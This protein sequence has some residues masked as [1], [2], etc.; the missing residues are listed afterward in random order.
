M[1]LNA[2]NVHNTIMHCLFNDEELTSGE[3]IS[4]IAVDG[5]TCFFVFNPERLEEKWEDISSMLDCLPETFKNG[6]SFLNACVTKDDEHWGEHKDMDA[7]FSLGLAINRVNLAFPRE[8]WETL[9]G[10]M[11]Y[12]IVKEAE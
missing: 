11:P 2:L 12:Y 3:P 10:G 9:P 4:G 6:M 7:L 1:E 5:I 8:L